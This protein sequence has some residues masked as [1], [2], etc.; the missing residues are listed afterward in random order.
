MRTLALHSKDILNEKFLNAVRD[1][2]AVKHNHVDS[3][4]RAEILAQAV[5][6]ALDQQLPDFPSDVKRSLRT[7]LLNCARNKA[8][9]RITTTDIWEHCLKLQPQTP[10]LLNS[11]KTWTEKQLSREISQA[12][13]VKIVSG[14]T[15]IDGKDIL[16]EEI[17]QRTK[18][19]RALIYVSGAL[20]L[21]VFALFPLF[22]IYIEGAN[23]ADYSVR[24]VSA[25]YLVEK[26][27]GPL[28][29]PDFYSFN[30]PYPG[31]YNE[32][33]KP[34]RYEEIDEVAVKSYLEER[35]SIL[36]DDAY[37]QVIMDT[38]RSYNIH[39]LLLLAITGQEQG[40]VPRDHPD[41]EQIANNPFNVYYSWRDY[42]T[43]IEDSAKIAAVTLTNLIKNR[44]DHIHPLA[45]INRKYAEDENWWIGVQRLFDTLKNIQNNH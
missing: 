29:Q 11:L 9:F 19:P 38:A 37:F 3:A 39:P 2:I 14:I 28:F 16:K 12:E 6:Q 21:L 20:A 44:P 4:K 5:H 1:F 7:E 17:D 27:L 30:V 25:Y 10:E 24:D 26:Q 32:L 23:K 36:T 15:Q 43:T 40:F 18:Q 8:V 22:K 35:H 34:F 45:W 13:F 42:N 41:A 31:S 33:P